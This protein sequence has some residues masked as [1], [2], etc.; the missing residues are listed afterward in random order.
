MSGR[1]VALITG[2]G[3]SMGQATVQRLAE[4]GF[5]IAAMDINESG[6]REAMARVGSRRAEFRVVDQAIEPDVRGA[7]KELSE[8]LGPIEA[9][10]NP[11]GWCEG[12]L[13]SQE[14]A[15]YWDKVI[16]I[17]YKAPLYVT[18]PVLLGMIERQRGK[19]V[20]ITSDAAKV[21]TG[22]QAPRRPSVRSPRALPE[23]MHVTT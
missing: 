17:N 1:G 20:Y 4:D 21:G 23:K 3:G 6:L 5:D 13:F 15:D 2:A 7:V 19:I 8:Q 22:T 10:V 14:S 9:L 11:T 12:M 16:N 18:Q